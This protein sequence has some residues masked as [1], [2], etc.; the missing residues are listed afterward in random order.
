MKS[1]LGYQFDKN[2]G[3][4]APEEVERKD[5]W[6]LLGKES[7]DTSTEL[8]DRQIEKKL[9]QLAE[10]ETLRDPFGIRSVEVVEGKSREISFR[11]LWER[12]KDKIVDIAPNFIISEDKIVNAYVASVNRSI[13]LSKSVGRF[14]NFLAKHGHTKPDKEHHFKE[15]DSALKRRGEGAL[16]E[17]YAVRGLYA[18]KS[19]TLRAEHARISQYNIEKLTERPIYRSSEQRGGYKFE[20]LTQVVNQEGGHNTVEE[21]VGNNLYEDWNYCTASLF[22]HNKETGDTLELNELLPVGFIFMPAEMG[23]VKR[24]FIESG[25]GDNRVI[26]SENLLVPVTLEAYNGNQAAEDMFY[27]NAALERVGY[28]HLV[29]KGDL[30][31]LLH[32]IAHA[33]QSKYHSNKGRAN[34]ERFHRKVTLQLELLQRFTKLHQEARGENSDDKRGETTVEEEEEWEFDWAKRELAE[35]GVSIGKD[36][37]YTDQELGSD[38]FKISSLEVEVKDEDLNFKRNDFYIQS[39]KIRPLI[40][41]F[42]R[43]ERDAW[44]HALRVLRFLRQRGF[45]LEPELKS[46]KDIQ[47]MIHHCLGTY[48][49]SLQTQI[50]L[51]KHIRKFTQK[52]GLDIEGYANKLRKAREEGITD[53]KI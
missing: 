19:Q 36:Y 10:E 52:S 9:G 44:A 11:E 7:E 16:S 28:G 5:P 49:A 51:N 42:I 4:E 34:W 37:I 13:K 12:V 1:E 50:G 22:I 47:D 48:Q 25:E 18:R 35:V 43:E 23:E 24:G 27:A 20:F 6:G 15:T 29:K 2:S 17:I 32:E 40:E 30:L 41:D 46:L 21:V 39:D 31:T 53:S 45:D 14:Y 8:L 38:K 26:K 3:S 33:W